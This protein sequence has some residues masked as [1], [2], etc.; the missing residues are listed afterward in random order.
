MREY[1]YSLMTDKRSGVFASVLKG[2]LQLIS[3]FYGIGAGLRRTAY[4]IG[5]FKAHRAGC[6]VISV[7]NI[8]LGGTGKTPM[9]CMLAKTLKGHNKTVALLTR[10]YGNDEWKMMK[11][12]LVDIPVIVGPDRVENSAKAISEF[13]ADTVIL[14]DGFQHL[15]IK[16]DLDIVLIDSSN[17]FGNERLFPRGVLREDLYALKRADMLFLTKTDMKENNVEFIKN[18]LSMIVPN[19]P[20]VESVYRP[21]YFYNLNNDAKLDLAEIKSKK[22]ATL[23]SIVNP[24]YF[25]FM[26]KNLGVELKL[27]LHY[28]DHYSYKQKDLY[29]IRQKCKEVGVD[30]I[31]TTEK[32]AVKLKSYSLKLTDIKI[33]I[34]HIEPEITKGEEVFNRR[35]VSVYRA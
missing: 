2:V 30:T 6:K 35:L 24:E 17:P 31:V 15:R 4:K 16:K 8:S 9:S 1:I 23:S 19:L 21:K 7:G 11:R 22:I 25:E 12:F 32:D 13:K 10:G 34:L 29:S 20:M 14:D 27:Q 28:P 3:W 18:K 33:L 26:L 5:I